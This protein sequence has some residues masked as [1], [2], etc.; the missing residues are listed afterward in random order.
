[1]SVTYLEMS[2]KYVAVMVEIDRKQEQQ[3]F[4]VTSRHWGSLSDYF[5]FS[6]RNVHNNMLGVLRATRSL[7]ITHSF[8][9]PVLITYSEYC[10]GDRATY[11]G[12]KAL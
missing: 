10:S 2:Q 12:L 11:P 7:R 4:T 3:M 8:L 9:R 1:M 5:K 6:I